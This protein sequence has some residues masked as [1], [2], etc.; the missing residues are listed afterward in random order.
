[1]LGARVPGWSHAYCGHGSRKAC[2]RALLRSLRAA[3]KVTPQE[4]Y[5]HG[6][7]E[8]NPNPECFD[9]NR[10]TVASGIDIG[11]APFQNRPTFQQTVS[12]SHGVP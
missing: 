5:G 6:E 2:R 4:L 10:S 3:L 11:S 8:S 12:L 1:V 9:R 7:C